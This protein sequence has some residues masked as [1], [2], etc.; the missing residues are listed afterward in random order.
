MEYKYNNVTNFTPHQPPRRRSVVSRKSGSGRRVTS[1]SS[2]T[3]SRLSG[4]WGWQGPLSFFFCSFPVLFL[5]RLFFFLLRLF[6]FLSFSVFPKYRESKG[7]PAKSR[8]PAPSGPPAKSRPS[9]PSPPGL[10]PQGGACL[11]VLCMPPCICTTFILVKEKNRKR[12][13]K[14]KT[15]APALYILAPSQHAFEG[16]FWVLFGYNFTAP[17]DVSAKLAALT[18]ALGPYGHVRP[19]R[20]AET[21]TPGFAFYGAIGILVCDCVPGPCL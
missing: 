7:P 4:G 8:P 21:E 10:S 16:R 5:L 6:F 3:P 20:A 18:S 15:R 13:E 14:K 19:G 11:F 1:Y 17:M 9:A 2:Y 12:T